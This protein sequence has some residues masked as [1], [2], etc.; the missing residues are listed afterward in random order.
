LKK[1]WDFIL[2][3]I[4]RLKAMFRSMTK[5]LPGLY[6]KINHPE[7]LDL[8]QLRVIL[9]VDM[10]IHEE[11]SELLIGVSHSTHAQSVRDVQ[12]ELDRIRFVTGED[13]MP[14]FVFEAKADGSRTTTRAIRGVSRIIHRWPSSL[15][16][17]SWAPSLDVQ[18]RLWFLAKSEGTPLPS[19]VNL[20]FQIIECSFPDTK[21][22]VAYPKFNNPAHDPDPRTECKLLRDLASHGKKPAN[23]SQLKDYCQKYGLP[24]E[25]SDPAGGKVLD[26]LKSKIPLIEQVARKI[27]ENQLT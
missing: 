22:P 16:Q 17:Q 7:T 27:I 19:K 15:G 20:L 4:G 3:I 11:G 1:L 25:F 24:A 12:R 26:H 2:G 9:P 23:G 6:F 18:L 21:D 5:L 8:V 10:T 13:L 14:V